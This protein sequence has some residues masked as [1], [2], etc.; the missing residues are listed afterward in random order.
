[1]LRFT[2]SHRVIIILYPPAQPAI[3]TNACLCCVMRCLSCHST[4]LHAVSF[5]IAAL[6]L[7]TQRWFVKLYFISLLYFHGI[8]MLHKLLKFFHIV[9][10]IVKV[11]AASGVLLRNTPH[12]IAWHGMAHC[13]SADIFILMLMCRLFCCYYYYLLLSLFFK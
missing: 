11:I 13:C 1:M 8:I 4:H 2:P 5:L 12:R 6:S 7:I 10:V 9:S 3:P